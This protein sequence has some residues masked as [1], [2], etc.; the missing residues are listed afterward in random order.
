MGLVMATVMPALAANQ[1]GNQITGP[2]SANVCLRTLTKLKT[3]NF[4][5]SGS[6]THTV[7]SVANSGNNTA[8]MNTSGGT[9]GTGHVASIVL[10]QAS[11]NTGNITATQSDPASDDTGV[12]DTTGP[13]SNNSVT[14]TTT[15]TINLDL[16]NSGTVTHNADSNANSGHNSASNNTIGGV[17]TTG[18]ASSDVSV[19]TIM[20]DFNINLTQ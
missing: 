2:N 13:T 16:T 6:V 10:K 7:N 8:D 11:L 9:V 1:C 20:N 5:N 18:N 3:L 15:K 12:N 4:T 19:I 14:L 17:V